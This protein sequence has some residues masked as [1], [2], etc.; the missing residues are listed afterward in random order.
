MTI[1]MY[2]VL[3]ISGAS[4]VGFALPLRASEHHRASIKNYLSSREY[5]LPSSYG[6]LIPSTISA[7]AEGEKS[8][9]MSSSASIST[10]S[11]SLSLPPNLKDPPWACCYG[12]WP[13]PG[14]R[15]WMRSSNLG[16]SS[17]LVHTWGFSLLFT[18]NPLYQ[19]C[20]IGWSSFGGNITSRSKSTLTTLPTKT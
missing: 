12:L 15:K 11:A 20:L 4:P 18:R 7:V 17:S 10:C 13:L 9:K 6:A 19:V 2:D 5:K 1:T 3:A 14:G 16:P 8:L